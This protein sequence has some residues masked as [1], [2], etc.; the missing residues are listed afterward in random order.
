MAKN[1]LTH[2]ELDTLNR[3]VT[4]YLEF[5]ELQAK[6]RK[7]MTMK[8]W[9][10]KLDDFLKIS[11]KEILTHAGKISHKMANDMANKEYDEFSKIMI[12]SKVEQDFDNSLNE[13]QKIEKSFPLKDSRDVLF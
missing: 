11:D 12:S 7:P 9:I 3:I 5:A 13:M 10:A 4:L 6:N 8:D 2:D 1:Y